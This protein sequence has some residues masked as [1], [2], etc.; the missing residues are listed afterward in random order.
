MGEAQRRAVRRLGDLFVPAEAQLWGMLFVLA[1]L[2]AA[3]F[4]LLK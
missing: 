2:I 1:V 4:F 3:T